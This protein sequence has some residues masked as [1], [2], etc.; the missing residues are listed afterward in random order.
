MASADVVEME[1][2][3][4]AISVAALR[5]H[6]AHLLADDAELAAWCDDACLRRYL[7]ARK[8]RV[9][10]AAMMCENTL[11]WRQELRPW[12]KPCSQCL[13][14]PL[15]HNLRLVGFDAR[16]RAVIF[17]VFAQ[18][19]DRFR[20]TEAADHLTH[21]LEQTQLALAARAAHPATR[22]LPQSEQWV[23]VVDFYGF[24][25]QDNH[26]QT[27]L[28]TAALLNHYPERLGCCVLFGAPALFS[29]LWA[30]VKPLLDPVTAAKVRFVSSQEPSFGD[31]GLGA[32]MTHWLQKECAEVRRDRPARG[33][34]CPAPGSP[35][36]IEARRYWLPPPGAPPAGGG[37]GIGIGGVGGA[38]N[39]H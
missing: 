19:H 6:V 32:E 29:G 34:G 17:T 15:A 4:N 1:E 26:P 31:Y 12:E 22:T 36:D 38:L 39:N 7:R 11:R 33:T 35:D 13:A 14:N 2:P 20:P 25:L 16:G 10:Q 3:D 37:G 28:L 9:A 30:V 21:C 24:A 8:G 27:G 18:A 23:W 5:S